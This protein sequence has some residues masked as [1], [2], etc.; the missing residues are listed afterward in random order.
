M[1]TSLI[2]PI[3]PRGNILTLLSSPEKVRRFGRFGK[4]KMG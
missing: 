1:P 4:G 3:L 2:W